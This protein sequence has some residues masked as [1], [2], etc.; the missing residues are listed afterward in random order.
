[1]SMA[2]ALQNSGSSSKTLI[3]YGSDGSGA[4]ASPSNPLVS[5]FD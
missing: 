3:M 1:M 5:N 4:L 2:G